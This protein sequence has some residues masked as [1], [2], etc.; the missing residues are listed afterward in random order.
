MY[1]SIKNYKD[2][3]YDP[4]EELE[5]DNR[6]IFHEIRDPD[7]KPVPWELLPDW[8]IQISPYQMATQEEF[9]RAVDQILLYYFVGVDNEGC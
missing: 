2:F 4:W 6:K 8:F 1:H 7:G 9:N 3:K 5:D